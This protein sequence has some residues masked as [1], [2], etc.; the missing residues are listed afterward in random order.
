M[1]PKF[2]AD[3]GSGFEHPTPDY[4]F[5]A[6]DEVFGPFTFDPATALG[7]H[8]TDVILD[9][10]GIVVTLDGTYDAS[11]DE[12][13]VFRGTTTYPDRNDG[14]S[15][16]WFGRV[17]MNH[18][19]GREDWRWVRRAREQVRNGDADLVCALVPVKASMKWWRNYIMFG[20]FRDIDGNHRI[21]TRRPG[22]ADLVFNIPGR[23]RFGD[24][25]TG[26]EPY[27]ATFSSAL[28]VFAKPGVVDLWAAYN[29]LERLLGEPR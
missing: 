28:A 25:S 1:S 27:S 16:P 29:D 19:Y 26:A 2:W 24:S 22:G 7:F 6:C 23:V 15:E 9:R 8:T 14:L 18:P 12:H 20:G 3:A 4:I 5:D 21:R 11:P 17:W 13:P 10:G